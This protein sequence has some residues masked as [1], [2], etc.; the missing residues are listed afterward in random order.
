MHMIGTISAFLIQ[1][2][3]GVSKKCFFE[4]VTLRLKLE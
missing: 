1:Y 3:S 2:N 4:G